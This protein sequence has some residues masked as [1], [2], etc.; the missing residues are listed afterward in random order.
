MPNPDNQPH[1]RKQRHYQHGIGP[2]A[3]RNEGTGQSYCR[4]ALCR[5]GKLFDHQNDGQKK[6]WNSHECLMA[7][8]DRKQRVC[9][10]Q[11]H[12][13][14]K[15]IPPRPPNPDEGKQLLRREKALGTLNHLRIANDAANRNEHSEE[16]EIVPHDS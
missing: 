16:D 2:A 6:C 14:N 12:S 4:C 8:E 7:R 11:W 10:K 5:G 3:S 15:R 13:W 1:T 9:N